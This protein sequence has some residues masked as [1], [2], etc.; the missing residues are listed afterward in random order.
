MYT[1]EVLTAY[2]HFLTRFYLKPLYHPERN[3]SSSFLKHF[4]ASSI[5]IKCANPMDSSGSRLIKI[6]PTIWNNIM[7]QKGIFVMSY[8]KNSMHP[9]AKKMELKIVTNLA[10]PAFRNVA[11][12]IHK[13]LKPYCDSSVLDWKE[14]K[15]GG[16]ILF[17]ET[18]RRDTLKLIKQLL[19]GSKIVFYGTTEGRSFLDQESIRVARKIGIVAVSGFVKQMLEEVGVPVAGIVHHGLDMDATEIDQSF[20]QSL[21]EK[22]G[23]K[24][25]AL[26]I[27][28]NDPRK[29]LKELLLSYKLVESEV[30]NSFLIL[31]SQPARYYSK[32]KQRIRKRHYDF[33]RLM[34]KIG[35]E[36]MW[37][38][39]RHGLMTSNEV[40]TLYELCQIYVLSSFCEGFGLPMLEA[41]RFNKPVIALDTPPFNEVIE[42]GQ[43]GRLIP[44]KEVRWF[45]YL[46]QILFKMH[47]YEPDVLA[48]AM[49][50]LLTNDGLRENM[51]IKIQERRHRWSIHTLYP[52]LLDYF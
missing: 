22:T 21:R 6:K 12:D 48:E 49:V 13:A 27:A 7:F 2:H 30:P 42:D 1:A 20:L 26:T 14:A 28:S 25:V 17:I 36:R 38:T 16:N 24:L 19:P 11:L 45:N 35:V 23:E 51:K 39:D 32:T 41:F 33:P 43:T 37:L 40:N 44:Y 9:S 52:R 29:G 46:N 18:V 31:H 8:N 3:F 34:S 4:Y 10:W 5:V 47:I 50:S 15:Q